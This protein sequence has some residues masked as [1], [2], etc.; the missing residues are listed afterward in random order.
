MA[1][2]N[3]DLPSAH[4][5]SYLWALPALP[6][7]AA[8]VLAVIGR[9]LER[10]LG[11]GATSGLLV[12]AL[13]G[14]VGVLVAAGVSGFFEAGARILVDAGGALVDAGAVTVTSTLVLDRVRAALALAIALAGLG[15]AVGKIARAA[16]EVRVGAAV[17]A[18]AC[19]AAALLVV[20]ADDALLAVVAWEA[21][22]WAAF[23]LVP[24]AEAGPGAE[25][26]GRAA[27]PLAISRAGQAAWLAALAL[28]VWGLAGRPGHVTADVRGEAG[29]GMDLRT[30][31]ERPPEANVRELPLG[32]TVAP[33]EV[34]RQL[35]LRDNTESFPFREALEARRV[36]ALPLVL[37]VCLALLLGMAALVAASL[38]ACADEPR[39]AAGL[40]WLIAAGTVAAAASLLSRFWF[41]F[42]LSVLASVVGGAVAALA[43]ATG[44]VPAL[45]ARVTPALRR[46]VRELGVLPAKDFARAAAW[47]DGRV[48]APAGGVLALA[49]LVLALVMLVRG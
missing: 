46:M 9:A 6:A 48:L 30:R 25:N 38:L 21:F 23:V 10:R 32:P 33:R 15:V 26:T 24:R 29:A 40:G 27:E 47:L 39:R 20:L 44:V 4:A 13:G 3:V 45:R 11:R 34:A 19:A 12:A 14:V 31:G 16:D 36:G 8:V 2:Y 28:L 18:A 1:I 35:A 41:L 42:R 7:V 43:A 5:V 49:A 37:C 22:A 17:A